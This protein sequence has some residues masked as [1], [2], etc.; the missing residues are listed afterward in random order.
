MECEICK[1]NN[2]KGTA[3]A[4]VIRDGKLLVL[5]RNEEPFKDMWDLPGGYMS[6]GEMP[7]DTLRKELMEELGVEC[8][9]DFIN[10]FPGTASWKD[11]TF[12]ILSHAY[13]ADIKGDIKL[14]QDE[15]SEYKWVS[16][17]ELD[18]DS[19][20]FDSNQTITKYIK[21]KFS[22]DYIMLKEL[23][24]QLDSSA[25]VRE[26]NYYRSVLNG[27]ISKKIV[28]GRLAGVGWIFP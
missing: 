10:W 19:I 16:L 20:A 18:P 9:L 1:F 23:I 27:Y 22:V 24:R 13:L 15:N 21:E 3:T 8:E 7:E 4:V 11:R 14:N 26:T 12:A 6:Q 5:K 28:D 17:E 2:P 25:E